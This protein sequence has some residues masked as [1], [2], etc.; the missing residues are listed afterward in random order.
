M[1]VVAQAY[2]FIALHVQNSFMSC[3][4]TIAHAL[5]IAAGIV[6]LKQTFLMMFEESAV[7]VD[8]V[9]DKSGDVS[10]EESE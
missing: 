1:P 9:L 8:D 3:L 6:T 5:C 7:K 10:D 4:A 2:A